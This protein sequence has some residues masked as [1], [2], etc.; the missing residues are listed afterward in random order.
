MDNAEI[1]SLV[2][3]WGGQD[4]E[5]FASMQLMRPYSKGKPVLSN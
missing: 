4:E 1:K 2:R 3:E 5:A